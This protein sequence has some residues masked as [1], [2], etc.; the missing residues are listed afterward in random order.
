M[1]RVTLSTVLIVA[2]SSQ[3]LFGQINLVNDFSATQGGNGL[4]YLAVGD[5]RPSNT[6]N[7]GAGVSLMT[8]DGVTTLPNGSANFSGPLF[9]GAGD[10]LPYVQLETTR[11]FLALHPEALVGGAIGAGVEWVVPQSGLLRIDVDF[12]RAND[13]QLAGNGVDVGIYVNRNFAN[14]VFLSSISSNHFVNP[15]LPFNG[16]AVASFDEL[17]NLAMGDQVLFAVFSDAQGQDSFFDVT[18]L[19]GSIT[20]VPEPATT[21]L[22]GFVLVG[23]LS[24]CRSKRLHGWR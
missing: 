18:A 8:F 2:L 16:T 17:I 9:R 7:P 5:A 11:G 19:R 14:P 13:A 1:V 21:T 24:V 20:V 22:A 3:C 15:N 10:I 23:M 4:S 12:A 6:T